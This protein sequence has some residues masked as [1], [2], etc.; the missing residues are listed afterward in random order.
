[1]CFEST[2]FLIDDDAAVR[3][4]LSISLSMASLKTEAYSSGKA[5]LAAYTEDRPGCLLANLSQPEM[6]GLAVQQELIRRNFPIP[7]IFMTAIGTLYNAMPALQYDA[8]CL[9][10]KPFSRQLL[11]ESLRAAMKQDCGNRAA[12]KFRA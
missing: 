3:D 8:F 7:V 9:L 2:V 1:M 10:E 4:A 5:F 11:L 12:I 6:E